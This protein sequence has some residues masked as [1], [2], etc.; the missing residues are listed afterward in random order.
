S[1]PRAV[2]A[3]EANLS[4]VGF[5]GREGIRVVCSDAVAFLSRWQAGRVGL[6][7]VD[8]P[9]RYSGWDALLAHLPADVAVLEHASSIEAG[10]RYVTLR[11]Y[12]YGGTLVTLVASTDKDPP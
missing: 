12:R 9:Y 2:A 8:P 6:G 7:L 10:P 3:I 11:E 1:D 4:S 5:A